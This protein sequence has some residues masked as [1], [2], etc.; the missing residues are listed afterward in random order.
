MGV[1]AF[2]CASS[3]V[4][5][6]VLKRRKRDSQA[7]LPGD[8]ESDFNYETFERTDSEETALTVSAPAKFTAAT[9]T[10]AS[11]GLLAIRQT[12]NVLQAAGFALASLALIPLNLTGV[13]VDLPPLLGI[14]VPPNFRKLGSFSFLCSLTVVSALSMRRLYTDSTKFAIVATMGLFPL[15]LEVG[16][17]S[18]KHWDHVQARLHAILKRWTTEADTLFMLSAYL[19]ELIE[20]ILRLESM[21]DEA[22]LGNQA[23]G[24]VFSKNQIQRVCKAH[25]GA[26]AA[27][28]R[29]AVHMDL[30]HEGVPSQLGTLSSHAA[31]RLIG[32]FMKTDRAADMLEKG[33]TEAIREGHSVEE[34]TQRLRAALLESIR[35][36]LTGIAGTMR[37]VFRFF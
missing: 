34:V 15:L 13:S 21:H 36:D 14:Y 12:K 37:S 30:S 10:V 26:K 7:L 23:C 8:Q 35:K 27:Q 22:K 33:L 1:Y 2:V 32:A 25:H 31:E 20:K 4:S 11:T 19:N 9:V 28:L 17:W 24:F 18:I 5:L 6:F 29:R 16:D 3:S